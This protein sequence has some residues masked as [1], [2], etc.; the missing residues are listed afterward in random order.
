MAV[1]GRATVWDGEVAGMKGA[2]TVVDNDPVLILP[3]SQTAI[4]AV[5]RASKWGIA[6]TRGLGEVVS[7]ISECEEEYVAGAV[8]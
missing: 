3:D 1:G 7:L 5:R 2:L 4:M 8:S 6:R